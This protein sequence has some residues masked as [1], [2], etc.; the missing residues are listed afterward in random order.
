MFNAEALSLY[1]VTDEASRCRHALL[2]TVRMA[3]A[4][5]VSM[6]QYRCKEGDID[7]KLSEARALQ[8]LLAE[9]NVPFIINDEL[10]IAIALN[11]DGLHIGQ[12]DI[13]PEEARQGLGPD[14]ILGLTVNNAE[15]LKRVPQ[16]VVDY[17]GIGPVFTTISKKNPAPCLGVAGLASL[18]AGTDLPVVAIGGITAKDAPSIRNEA[19]AAGIA[20]VSAICAADDPK[21]AAQQFLSK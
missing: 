20:I 2:D 16:G 21:A 11:A 4:G 17:L 9:L 13:S 6:V 18:V 5:G 7:T 12:L 8:A 14:K 10:A 15:Q 1:L 3:V 19:G